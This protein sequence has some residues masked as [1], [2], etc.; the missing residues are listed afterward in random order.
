MNTAPVRSASGP[1]L[2]STCDRSNRVVGQMSG[3]WV[4]PKNTRNGR[5]FMSRSVNGL[6]LWSSRR[7]GPPTLAT[8]EPIGEETRPVTNRMAP[9]NSTSPPRNAANTITMRDVFSFTSE[10]RS[11][12]T[13]DEAGAD[14]FKK[15]RGSVMRP[16]QGRGRE[17]GAGRGGGSQHRP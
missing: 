2:R 10:L 6:P 9:K 12:E 3:Q 8:A 14:R 13:G 15:N 11:A 1:S 5:P 7:N 4:K 17:H 16:Q